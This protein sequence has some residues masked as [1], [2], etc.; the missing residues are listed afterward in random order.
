ME[1]EF[2]STLR[3]RGATEYREKEWYT[4]EIVRLLNSATLRDAMV[5]YQF[6]TSIV[7]HRP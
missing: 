6:L 1:I 3:T 2:Q 5:T 4:V 7:L